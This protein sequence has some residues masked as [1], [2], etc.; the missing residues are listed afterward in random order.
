MVHSGA[1][2][3]DVTKGSKLSAEN[4]NAV[5]AA[6]RELLQVQPGMRVFLLEPARIDPANVSASRPARNDGDIGT[7]AVSEGTA[8]THFVEI[9]DVSSTVQTRTIKELSS[10][11]QKKFSNAGQKFFSRD[12]VFLIGEIDGS[13]FPIKL[14]GAEAV[15][16]VT[17]GGVPGA[18]YGS[19]EV[20]PGFG[21]MDVY[22]WSADGTK[23][24]ITNKSV[25]VANLAE[26]STSDIPS[27][28]KIM[29]KMLGKVYVVDWEMCT[30]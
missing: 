22:D 23:L 8:T 6:V 28:T 15:F 3:Q 30:I 7:A 29:C 16:G 18:V 26:G 27:G 24:V 9:T 2:F 1:T 5:H 25:R 20:V 19:G 14:G 11:M 13:Y 17:S 21:T 4:M 12:E 10:E